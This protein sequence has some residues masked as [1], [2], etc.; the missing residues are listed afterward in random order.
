MRVTLK[1]GSFLF[2]SL[3]SA[4]YVSKP[5]F[6]IKATEDKTNMSTLIL[7]G[8]GKK[9]LSFGYLDAGNRSLD[10]RMDHKGC[11]FTIII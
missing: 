8:P 3:V 10:I 5:I 6:D 2:G 7:S 1:E 9:V 11:N 4:S